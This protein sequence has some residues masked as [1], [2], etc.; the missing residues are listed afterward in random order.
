MA[1]LALAAGRC[2]YKR[3]RSLFC[4]RF[5]G[6]LD[7]RRAVLGTRTI[8]LTKRHHTA[9]RKIGQC[10]TVASAQAGRHSLAFA[11]KQGFGHGT[12]LQDGGCG[13]PPV[14]KPGP[15]GA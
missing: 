15:D 14:A 8:N 13:T 7:G 6:R 5:F 4:R 10:V 9:R 1:C 2:E 12:R 3:D 11:G